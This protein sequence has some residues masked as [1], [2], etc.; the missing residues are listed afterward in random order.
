MCDIYLK[1]N[2]FTSGGKTNIIDEVKITCCAFVK[3]KK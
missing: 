2:V 3:I 1:K